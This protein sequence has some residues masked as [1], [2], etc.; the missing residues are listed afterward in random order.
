MIYKGKQKLGDFFSSR[1]EKGK[2]G[3]P[4]FSVTLNEGLIQRD[5]LG[6]KTVTN[7]EPEQH[8]LIKNGDIAY[9]MM[10]M[11]QGAHG[12]AKS[13]GIVS[14]AYI[15][16][17]PNKNIDSEYAYHLFKTNRLIYLFWAYSYGLTSDRLRLYF[18]DFSKI[19]ATIPTL[20]E[21]TKIA[22]ILS[23]WDK[24]IATV[25]A[26]I[27]NSKA[28]KKA[29][30]QQLLTG[31]KRFVEFV[32]EWR[33]TSVTSMGGVVSGG[34]PN[35]TIDQYWNGEVLW[36]TPTDVTVL[37]NRFVFDTKKKI[38]KE[39]LNN[40]SASIVPPGS[41]LVCT[42]ATIGFMAISTT[43]ITT[44]QGFKNLV[45]KEIFDVNFLYYLFLF[46]RNKFIKYACGST[47]LELSGSD[48]KKL[49]FACPGFKEQQKIALTL[50]EL[51][52]EIERLNKYLR[53]LIKEKKSLMQQLLAGKR[54]VE[55]RSKNQFIEE[56]AN[57]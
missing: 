15:V 37:R 23:T 36:M 5:L 26:L 17:K 4:T 57:A 38:S 16:L 30:M 14:P 55:I 41:L 13:K 47:F 48:F 49:K 11:W 29:L 39:G 54:R 45:P 10:R 53:C 34:T 8:L 31:K 7:L 33:D 1:R 56:T 25:E 43:D 52:L 6:R 21:Q 12:L 42:R 19:L 40:S 50:S 3:L 9:N 22:K 51:D 18:N 20:D 2:A 32:E 35:T 24:A 44:N 28:Q 46:F 27:E